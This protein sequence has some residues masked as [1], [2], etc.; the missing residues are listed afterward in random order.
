MVRFADID[1]HPGY[2]ISS[3]GVVYNKDMRP[4]VPYYHSARRYLAVD[5]GD[6]RKKI[7]ILVATYFCKN[8]HGKPMV[9]H[10]NGIKIDNWSGNLEW[11][12]NQENMK[13]A[14]D[15]GLIAYSDWFKRNAVIYGSRPNRAVQMLDNLG[16]VISEYPS[17]KSANRSL[18]FQIK[19]ALSGRYKTAHGFYFK[20]KI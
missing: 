7:H 12:T 18:G 19:G 9:N 6:A 11:V 8:E 4:L 17:V 3:L 10:K 13:H 15:T 1:G 20:Y 2:K 14:V 5:I 16:N